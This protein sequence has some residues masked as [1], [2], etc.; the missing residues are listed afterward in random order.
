MLSA[1]EGLHK[2]ICLRDV[3]HTYGRELSCYGPFLRWEYVP[4]FVT[5]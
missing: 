3:E 1:L 4:R 2:Y 5:T